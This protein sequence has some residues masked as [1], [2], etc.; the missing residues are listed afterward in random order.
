MPFRCL[1]L[2][3][4]LLAASAFA[5]DWPQWRG[6]ER[7]GVAPGGTPLADAWP[8]TGPE[9]VW[10]TMDDNYGGIPRSHCGAFAVTGGSVFV[11]INHQWLMPAGSCTIGDSALGELGWLPGAG[12]PPKAL[13][14][15]IEAA[16][17]SPERAHLAPSGVDKWAEDWVEANISNKI[18]RLN[19]GRYAVA[20]LR[21]GSAEG[22]PKPLLDK[23]ATVRNKPFAGQTELD[24][25]LVANGFD[26]NARKQIQP[27]V[28][29]AQAGAS[30]IM[31]CLNAATGKEKWRVE[32][33]GKLQGEGGGSVTPCIVGDR[34]YVLGS[35]GVLF[36][37]NTQDGGIVWKADTSS[38]LPSSSSVVITDGKAI[39]AAGGRLLAFTTDAGTLAWQQPVAEGARSTSPVLWASGGKTYVICGFG[40]ELA[41]VDAGD[42]DLRWKIAH[43]G[44]ETT[45]PVIAGDCALVQGKGS[46]M[47]YMDTTLKGKGADLTMFKLSRA[48]ATQAWTIPNSGLGSCP[49]VYDG[50]VYANVGGGSST[51]K[52][53][54]MCVKL[55]SGQVMWE[56]ETGYYGGMS[57]ILADGKIFLTSGL[58]HR[59]C[60]FRATPDKYELLS[61]L[62]Q[63]WTFGGDS[64]VIADGRLYTHAH[65]FHGFGIA[66]H[67]LRA[68]PPQAP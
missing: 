23:L 44:D 19:F 27:L 25:W 1:T 55:E 8:R 13:S 50:Y 63:V 30:D 4:L 41:C 68:Q 16:R 49:L 47:R 57:K 32:E 54:I 6:P 46:G 42:G 52:G 58:N 53:K 62:E 22:F 12:A 28:V 20:C 26:E 38:S 15:M 40:K 59:V 31:F 33:P 37:L 45:V 17:L 3:L 9:L 65:H 34:C 66:C 5:G 36:C 56:Q 60:M 29:V 7:N 61:E 51:I 2:P 67:D 48:T 43:G 24:Q 14:Q 10:A 11:Y 35:A 64:P 21:R 39:V 18:S